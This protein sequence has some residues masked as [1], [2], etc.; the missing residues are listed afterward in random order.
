MVQLLQLATRLGAD[1]GVPGGSDA[2]GLAGAGQLAAPSP[3]GAE[4]SDA[5]AAMSLDELAEEGRRLSGA[6][7]A[8]LRRWAA[9]LAEEGRALASGAMPGGWAHPVGGLTVPGAVVVPGAAA[10]VGVGAVGRVPRP[11]VSTRPARGRIGPPP[12]PIARAAASSTT[13]SRWCG[14]WPRPARWWRA[15]W[16]CGG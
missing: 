9:G 8:A 10:G 4:A 7:H 1:V 2:P 13:A 11:P 3:I 6:I 14:D 12:V 16:A 15:G 5:L